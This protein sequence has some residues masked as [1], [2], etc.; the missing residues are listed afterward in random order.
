VLKPG[1]DNAMPR[2]GDFRTEVA[3]ALG[4]IAGPDDKAA[5][6]TL[7]ALAAD[8]QIRDRNLKK[9]INDA[10]KKIQAKKS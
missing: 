8:R 10:L 3:D 4:Q 2:G 1:R 5:V 6:D 7:T 9:A